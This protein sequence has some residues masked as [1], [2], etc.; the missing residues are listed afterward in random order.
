MRNEAET[1]AELVDPKLRESGWTDKMIVRERYITK[2]MIINESGD[3][4][5]PRKPDY[6]LYYPDK[7]GV[8]LA[9]IEA[10]PESKSHLAGMQQAKEYM[11]ML[12]VP[13]AYSTNGHKIEEYD[14]FHKIQRTIDR[15]PS[16]EELWRRYVECKELRQI[17]E[18]RIEDPLLYPYYPFP[19]KPIRYYQEVAVKNAI[20]AILKGQKRILLTMATGSGKTYVAFQIAWKLYK[21]RKIRRIL[22]LVDRIFLRRQAHDA[23]YPFGN[24]REELV[25]AE[26]IPKHKD[27]YF[28]T[29][30]TL[31]TEKD[32]KRVYEHF[33]PDFFDMVIIDECHR[34]GWRRW[35]DILRYFSNAIHLGLTATPKRDDNIDTYAYFGKPVYDYPM[36]QGIEDGFL[37]PC[38]IIRVFTNIDK[39]GV[40]SITEV[41]SQGAKIEVPPGVELKE[42]YT[43]EEFER[44]ITLPDRT[45]RICEH[46]ARILESTGPKGKTAIFCV[47]QT[48]AAEVAK[49]LNNRFGPIFKV[50]NYAVRVVTDEPYAHEVLKEFRDSEKEFPVVTTTVDLLSTGVDIPPVRN[51]VFLKH[52]NSKVVFHQ[53]I[54]RGTR[55]DENSRKYMFRIIDYT[56]ATRLFD[57]WDL[58]GTGKR[59]EGPSDWYLSC[60]VIDA[61]TGQAIPNV[62]VVVIVTPS[63]PIHTRTDDNGSLLL[64]DMPRGSVKIDIA[65]SGYKRKETTV[66]TFPDPDRSVVISLEREIKERKEL[67]RAENVTVYIAEEGIVKVNALG[68]ELREAEYI[69]YC[70]NGLIKRITTLDDLK[71]IWRDRNKRRKFKEELKN[72]GIDLGVLSKLLKRPDVDEFDL[73]AH[74]LFKAPIISRDERARALLDMKREFL[75]KYG[76]QAREVIMELV[77]RYRMAGVDE[78]TDPMVFRT[79]PF[80]KWG[81]LK[82]VIELFGGI[83]ALKEAINEIEQGLYPE[84]GGGVI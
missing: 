54:G 26:R 44:E 50:S 41:K 64:K 77:D 59:P 22:Y 81:Y 42:C 57:E 19:D 6:I 60:K 30:Q 67:V 21:T 36:R 80:D 83:D 29:Y 55:I 76:P 37:A 46:L 28:A 12:G 24:A 5:P 48:H 39:A 49:E 8:P 68:N 73:I 52:I 71:R 58:P 3:R 62:S 61:E 33:D 75:E 13:F 66:P 47:T 2:G 17:P 34:S 74:L 14:D 40:L 35:H 69:E 32:G 51:I 15:F 78:V 82:G 20:E 4:L 53:I 7:S 72:M 45:K 79:P 25:G 65:A 23:F 11:K 70:R 84:F 16:P 63:K 27:I 1:R 31:Y 43:V 9:V 10:E 56:N 38:E 18:S